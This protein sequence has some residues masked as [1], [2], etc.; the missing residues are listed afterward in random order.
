MADLPDEVERYLEALAERL[1]DGL[2]ERLIA[3]WLIGSGGMGAFRP[4]ASD[5]DVAVVV[6]GPPVDVELR[7]L[8]V[9]ATKLEIVFYDRDLRVLFDPNPGSGDHWYV[10]DLAVAREHGRPLLGPPPW[11]L[12]GEIPREEILAALDASDRWHAEHEPDSPNVERGRVYRETGRWVPKSPPG[13]R[14]R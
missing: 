9:P 3:V 12:I 8:P 1:R 2:G 11:E 14:R 10:I 4:G 7:D 5:L 13:E 6:S